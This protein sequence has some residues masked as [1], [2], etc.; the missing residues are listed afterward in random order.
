MSTAGMWV[1]RTLVRLKAADA[2]AWQ[3]SDCQYL[4]EVQALKNAA[5]PGFSATFLIQ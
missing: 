2:V 5:L 4:Q 1:W 3:T